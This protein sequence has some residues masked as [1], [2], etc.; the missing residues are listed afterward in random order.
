KDGEFELY[1]DDGVSM[2]YE[3]GGCLR[4]HISMKTGERTC[5]DFTQEGHYETAVETM[6]ID[7]IH[8]EKAPY[9]VTLD[10]KELPHFLH[11]WTEAPARHYSR[12]CCQVCSQFA[13]QFFFLKTLKPSVPRIYL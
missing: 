9:W 7:M 1:E 6:A 11:R 3:Q 13:E 10:G 12:W 2:D 8:R 5:L 4:T